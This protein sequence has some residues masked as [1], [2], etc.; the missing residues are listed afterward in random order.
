[1]KTLKLYKVYYSINQFLGFQPQGGQ[2]ALGVKT[3]EF[4]PKNLHE[5]NENRV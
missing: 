5:N 1:M 4:F 3:I 2:G